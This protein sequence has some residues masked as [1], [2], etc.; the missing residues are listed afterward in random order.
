MASNVERRKLQAH[1]KLLLDTIKRQAG[2]LQKAILEGV[3]NGIESGSSNVSILFDNTNDKPILQIVD[4][5]CGIRTRDE[6]IKHFE[7]FGTPHEESENKRWAEFRMG[8]GQL[9]AHGRNVWRTS[10]F[11]MTVDINKDG[12]HYDLVEGL[13]PISGCRI[14]I[15]LYRNPIG[16]DFN[17]VD[18]MKSAVKRQI[19]F[20]DTDVL[21]N[22]EKL[23]TPPAECTWDQEDDY[24][25]YLFHTGMKLTL[26]NMGAY[27]KDY[28]ASAYGVTGT[29]VSKQMLKLNFARNEPMSDCL[30]WQNIADI[31][32]ENRQKK[33]RKE[34]R[35]TLEKHERIATLRDLHDG[36]EDY[37]D[38]STIGLITDTNGRLFNLN[39]LKKVTSYWTFAPLGDAVADK[40]IQDGTAVCLDKSLLDELDYSGEESNFFNWL[41]IGLDRDDSWRKMSKMYKPFRQLEKGYSRS[42]SIVPQKNMTL[43]EKRVV[44]ILED[45]DNRYDCFGHRRIVIGL[46]DTFQAW[47]DG[48]GWIAVSRDFL[49]SLR[50]SDPYHAAYLIGVLLHEVSH[51]EDTAGTHTHSFEFYRKFHDSV[52]SDG[53]RFWRH[54]SPMGLAAL[55]QSKIQASRLEE[56]QAKI[57]ERERK[58]KERRDRKLARSGKRGKPAAVASPP[59]ESQEEVLVAAKERVRE[60]MVKLTQKKTKRRYPLGAQ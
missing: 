57:E 55:F 58:A 33:V 3:M 17:S 34:R 21:F 53:G 9:F 52:F 27:V 43:V 13:D 36:V 28:D 23:N 25:Y 5:G 50:L 45:F 47:T 49:K 60:S 19:E 20:M 42:T 8:R 12:L 30:I 16:W 56:R 29:V 46:S 14:H 4:D 10:T 44:K 26:Y 54:Q 39:G 11:Q 38:V 41:I 37:R 32:Q 15:E 35:R 18:S 7:T 40:F 24:A 2:T 1:D 6:L 48:S 22:G 51:D 59:I 31:V